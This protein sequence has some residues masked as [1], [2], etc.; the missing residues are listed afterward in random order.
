MNTAVNNNAFDR[1]MAQ[2]RVLNDLNDG[3]KRTR[4]L[5]HQDAQIASRQRLLIHILA[6]IG[7]LL[8]LVSLLYRLYRRTRR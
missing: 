4:E 3:E 8:M 6:T 1:Q 2:L 5:E 7:L